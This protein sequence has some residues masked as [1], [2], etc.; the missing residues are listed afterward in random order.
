MYH[1]FIGAHK[2]VLWIRI[3]LDPHSFGCLGSR[4]VLGITI[5]IQKHGNLPKFV[6]KPG[7][8]PFFVGTGIFFD[9]LPA[10][11]IFFM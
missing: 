8:L 1:C 9:L 4:S 3:H 7:F 11:S 6:D 10:C 2:T 5:R